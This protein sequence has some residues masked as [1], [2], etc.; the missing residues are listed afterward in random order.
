[1]DEIE[2]S[3]QRASQFERQAMIN[4]MNSLRDLSRLV[5]TPESHN[6]KHLALFDA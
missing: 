1:M 6:A 3:F 4:A 2:C 5:Q